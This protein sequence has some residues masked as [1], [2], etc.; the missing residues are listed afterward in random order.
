MELPYKV[1][2]NNSILVKLGYTLLMLLMCS[3]AVFLSFKS[4]N[5]AVP[6]DCICAIT[7]LAVIGFVL[8]GAIYRLFTEVIISE[9]SIL[10]KNI[11]KSVKINKRDI[12]G[13]Q[14]GL[15]S[16]IDPKFRFRNYSYSKYI[17]TDSQCFYIY[18]EDNASSF[19]FNSSDEKR[20]IDV[21]DNIDKKLVNGL[22]IKPLISR[23]IGNL[24]L[25][26][27][28]AILSGWHLSI[29]KINVLDSKILF[30]LG[31]VFLGYS[32]LNIGLFIHTFIIR[33]TNITLYKDGVRITNR[34]KNEF[35]S[36]EEFNKNNADILMIKY[37]KLIKIFIGSY[38]FNGNKYLTNR[39]IY[40]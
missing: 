31:L 6:I 29:N 32:L 2:I 18:I 17:F 22:S 11:C 26:F 21:S 16:Y 1:K 19:Y 40:Y 7:I 25:F 37:N 10:I 3:G 15:H 24:F 23:N 20:P 33:K 36:Y 8:F 38:L 14:G 34:W 27:S 28:L 30:S 12:I 9:E 35:F 4:I 39:M 5:F 13:Y